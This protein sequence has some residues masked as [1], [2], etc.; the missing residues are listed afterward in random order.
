[1]LRFIKNKSLIF[2]LFCSASFGASKE[3]TLCSE[4]PFSKASL[5][6]KEHK[7][8][9]FNQGYTTLSCF[10][11]PSTRRLFHPFLDARFHTFNSG[12][13]ASNLGVGARFCALDDDLIVGINGYYDFRNY[14]RLSSHQGSLGLEILSKW[15]DFRINGYKPF[16]GKVEESS[17]AFY[18]FQGNSAMLSQHI[19]YSLPLADAEIGFTLPDPF[20]Q[21][22]LYLAFGG[23]Y[24][25]KTDAQNHAV[26]D[27]FGGKVR[28]KASPKEYLSFDVEYTKDALYGSRVNGA[29]SFN[30][31]LGKTKKIRK[32]K[33]SCKAYIDAVNRRTQET[34]HQEIIPFYSEDYK[35]EHTRSNTNGK[36][37]RNKNK[38]YHFIFVNNKDYPGFGPGSGSGTADDPYTTLSLAQNNSAPDDIIYVFYGKGNSS[39]YDEGF[40]FK[41]EQY[42]TSSAVDLS[43]DK[44]V[45][46]ASTPGLFPFLDNGK[47]PTSP[48]LL[49][50][51]TDLVTIS[52]FNISM[53]NYDVNNPPDVVSFA[54][55]GAI[56][57]GNQIIGA[58]TEPSYTGN[59][60]NINNPS[61]EIEAVNNIFLN[62][63]FSAQYGNSSS[64]CIIE[65]N[66]FKTNNL[67]NGVALNYFNPLAI[68]SGNNFSSNQTSSGYG[69]FAENYSTNP[70]SIK[71]NT[72]SSGYAVQINLDL[73]S[74]ATA[75]ISNNKLFLGNIG[76]NLEA[77]KASPVSITQNTINS[78][79]FAIALANS[80]EN[81]ASFNV[82]NNTLSVASAGGINAGISVKSSGNGIFTISDNTI[83]LGDPTI[84]GISLDLNNAQ[85]IKNE[86]TINTNKVSNSNSPLLVSSDGLSRAIVSVNGN[87]F[88]GK[89]AYVEIYSNSSQ[90][91]CVNFS[92]NV[93]GTINFLNNYNGAYT[94]FSVDGTK[95]SLIFENIFNGSPPIT[96]SS[97]VNFAP[98]SAGCA[99][100]YAVFV[101]NTAPSTGA[102]GS[103]ANPYPTLALA[104]ANSK[105]GDLIYVYAGD[106]TTKG[107][108]TGF[109]LKPNQTIAGS[110]AT[111][112]YNGTEIVGSGPAPIITKTSGSVLLSAQGSG[113]I[114][115]LTLSDS[116]EQDLVS[117]NSSSPSTLSISQSTFIVNSQDSSAL[118]VAG[119]IGETS[120]NLSNNTF[121]A[122]NLI[123]D[124]IYVAPSITSPLYLTI[125]SNIVEGAPILNNCKFLLNQGSIAYINNTIT[126]VNP[127]NFY[128]GSQTAT[129]MI[130]NFSNNLIPN[131]QEAV[132]IYPP[133]SKNETSI[134]QNLAPQSNLYF[135]GALGKSLCF[136]NFSSNTANAFYFPSGSTYNFQSYT[137]LD[138][139]TQNNTGQFVPQGTFT[140]NPSCP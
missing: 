55:T 10:L 16:S 101:N 82:L 104:E 124:L 51:S 99:P 137:S 83:A 42:L 52:G 97:S 17:S 56:I 7:G 95:Q 13:I 36:N 75:N 87:E 125:D 110:G 118:D 107:Y 138:G 112:N 105:A 139:L 30:V 126:T 111:F 59:C 53:K 11:S 113:S 70:I 62:G 93:L 77:N 4:H 74:N 90:S 123:N 108:D 12:Y 69:I 45:I 23:Y 106:G 89:E 120:I 109:V 46:P 44:I 91:T 60:V 21:V 54:S 2:L 116:I 48:T 96:A 19:R 57:T 79:S 85:Y 73:K 28:L 5:R 132:S 20:K 29:I 9:G 80:S 27:D 114:V 72:I 35:Y 94:V 66:T 26:G 31:K 122:K 115:G 49:A 24:L 134:I 38:K 102:N 135:N 63:S 43:L 33:A 98:P 67:S 8:L 100:F 103:F 14:K 1:M 22:N 41:T 130:A 121:E 50:S 58:F 86:L 68:V 6:H 129:S 18:K 127:G 47:N 39:G 119:A 84:A 25:F 64:Y 136:K 61:Y 32:S 117:F 34:V 76:I 131:A 40:T 88:G 65:N 81:S 37:G 3:D 92:G 15:V 78:Y 71:N 128:L 140:F 133:S